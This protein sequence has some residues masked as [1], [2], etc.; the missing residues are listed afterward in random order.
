MPSHL[1]GK[2]EVHRLNSPYALISMGLSRFCKRLFSGPEPMMDTR[3]KKIFHTYQF[4]LGF[5]FTN[6]LVSLVGCN[7]C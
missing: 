6:K 5:S 3:N 1:K 4:S 7:I 2:K